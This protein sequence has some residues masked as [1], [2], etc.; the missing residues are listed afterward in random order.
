MWRAIKILIS[1]LVGWF[2]LFFVI[3]LVASYYLKPK[4]KADSIL[5]VT[6]DG[7]I[8]DSALPKVEEILQGTSA[9]TTLSLTETLREAAADPRIL[10]AVV[11]VKQPKM[12]L[13]QIQEFLQG[14]EVFRA[15]G[16]SNVAFLET[17][18]E[19]G[20]GN[21]AYLLATGA[22]RVVLAPSGDI[23]LIGFR[24]EVPFL[25]E[26]LRRLDV[27]VYV[28]QRHAYKSL[29]DM[30]TREGMRPEQR[31]ATTA[32][33]AGMHNDLRAAVALRRHKPEDEVEGWVQ[34][35]PHGAADALAMG[36]VDTLAYW[37][38]VLGEARDQAGRD[39]PFV[40]VSDYRGSKALEGEGETLALIVGEGEIHR[41]QSETG[42]GDP[43]IGSDT[44]ARAF[45]LARD[46][47]VKGVLLR[48]NSPGGSYVASD[49]IRRE[50]ELTREQ[51]IPVVVS[52][53]NLAASGG[54]FISMDADYVVAEPAT[55][56]G[57]IG[58][59]AMGLSLRRAYEHWL[60]IKHDVVQTSPAAGGFSQLDF[61]AG[62]ERAR[63]AKT[64]DRVYDD[65]V[66]KAA[67]GRGKTHEALHEV[68]QG[69]IWTGRAALERGLVDALGGLHDALAHLK[70]KA[71][72]S[73]KVHLQSY[74]PPETGVEQL[75]QMLSG[76]ARM[77]GTWLRL[78]THGGSISLRPGTELPER[79]Q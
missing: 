51:G 72:V 22:D 24:S 68:A 7:E 38:S 16:K 12:G 63:I 57:S 65:F 4:V 5:L 77:V 20:P 49:L 46:D 79:I 70:E 2:L 50:V 15:S 47:K 66:A 54:Y 78:W 34:S 36:M 58:V 19:F 55:I 62:P 8:R 48:V 37:D 3:G 25:A 61:P 9:P 6:L 45:R 28:E 60:G 13:A 14:M 31:E 1:V 27:D 73:G 30:F 69:R 64:I 35:G 53:G 56:T 39:D 11:R 42:F 33:L 32:I 10:G 44:L 26:T 71:G 41:G 74:P 75:M 18:G 59:F 43:S 23:G 52:M 40:S 21:G 67:K 17:A 76:Q 29:P